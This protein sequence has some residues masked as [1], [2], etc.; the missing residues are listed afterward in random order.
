M[1]SSECIGKA[2]SDI[3]RRVII[4]EIPSQVSCQSQQILTSRPQDKEFSKYFWSFQILDHYSWMFLSW[5][6]SLWL[7]NHSWHYECWNI[8]TPTHWLSQNLFLFWALS[9]WSQFF[10]HPWFLSPQIR[11]NLPHTRQGHQIPLFPF[12]HADSESVFA[13]HTGEDKSHSNQMMAI[14]KYL[15]PKSPRSTSLPVHPLTGCYGM[16]RDGSR[17]PRQHHRIMMVMVRHY[18]LFIFCCQLRSPHNQHT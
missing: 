1:K 7:Q 3:R 14:S 18:Y 10:V 6:E 15:L 2:Q 9:H 11:H 13:S 17:P 12:C 16:L 5:T 8:R 4:S